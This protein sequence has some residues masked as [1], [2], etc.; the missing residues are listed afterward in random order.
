MS[1]VIAA[2]ATP[3]GRSALAVVRVAGPG[4]L[5]ACREFLEPRFRDGFEPRRATLCGVVSRGEKLDEAVAAYFPACSSPLGE[6]LVEISCHGS[7]AVVRA[8]LDAAAAAGARPA[9]PGEFTRR[10][11]V[12]GRLD[13]AQ[14][15]AVAALIEART[16]AARR[17]ALRQLDGGLSSALA[18]LRRPVFDLLVRVEARLDHPEED[19]PALPPGQAR[20][21]LSRC[22][23]AVGR[24]AATAQRGRPLLEG[25]RVCI[26]GRPN[27]GK[28][29]L[30]NALLGRERAIVSPEPGTTRD[31]L[32]EHA[33]LRGL[34]A[35]LVD[36]AGLREDCA[37]DVERSG[38]ERAR[39]ALE[40]SDLAVLVVDG[41]RAPQPEDEAVHA[42][43]LEAAARSGRPVVTVLSKADLARRCFFA[44]DVEVSS[45]ERRG[46]ERLVELAAGRLSGGQEESPVLVASARHERALRAAQREL[47]AAARAVLEHPGRWEDRAAF[48]LRE[49]LA[50]LDEITGKGADE[51]LLDAVFSRFCV[52]K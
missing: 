29:S 9:Q 17:A 36:T 1:D 12:N 16:D 14:A 42:R 45:L 41:S 51:E 43:V 19:I 35:V 23:Q 25:A 8:V 28:S 5:A 24:L 39:A 27:A 13:L 44:A 10:A 7:P 15:E 49:A 3:P 4:A 32:E 48:H 33:S 20:E 11:Y 22:A 37:G 34:P 52:G 38:V 46:L 2:V 31:T 26:V 30:L 47:D 18:A 50:R 6:E 40:T 21:E